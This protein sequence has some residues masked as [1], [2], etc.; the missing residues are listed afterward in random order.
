MKAVR[1]VS[2]TEPIHDKGFNDPESAGTSTY[3][4]QGPLVKVCLTSNP[5]SLEHTQTS[6][7][8]RVEDEI[9]KLI[10]LD[11]KNSADSRFLVCYTHSK[12]TNMHRATGG[13]DWRMEGSI[14][15][16]MRSR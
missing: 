16:V 3:F 10:T 7:A 9:C 5:Q 6:I 14:S 11:E 1:F 4:L 12:P 2:P 8:E 13:F 15:R